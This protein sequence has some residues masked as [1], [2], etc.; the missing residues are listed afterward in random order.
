MRKHGRVDAN[1][2]A[3]VRALEKAGCSVQSLSALGAGVPDLLV[4]TRDRNCL[5]EIK[6]SSKPPSARKLTPAQ[7]AWHKSWRGKVA[8]VTTPLEALE[9][10][11][12]IVP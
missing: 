2:E 5:L 3:I 10:V 4:G 6:D 12:G 11:F 8:V 7:E 9:A 1:Q